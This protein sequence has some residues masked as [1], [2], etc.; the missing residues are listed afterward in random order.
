MKKLLL[1]VVAIAI[2][3][4]TV[5]KLRAVDLQQFS[6]VKGSP[7]AAVLPRFT[8]SAKITE[9]DA[10]YTVLFDFTGQNAIVWPDVINELTPEQQD[11]MI[12]RLAIWLVRTKAGLEQ[13]TP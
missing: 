4:V 9:S 2:I 6:V 11:E 1:S 8:I 10:P 5:I 12:N 13:P 7:K 3:A